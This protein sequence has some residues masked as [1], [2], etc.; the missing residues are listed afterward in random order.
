MSHNQPRKIRPGNLIVIYRNCINK[1]VW[2]YIDWTIPVIKS[3][4]LC[5]KTR[6]YGQCFLQ[7]HGKFGKYNSTRMHSIRMTMSAAV[8]RLH[9]R[10]STNGV[11]AKRG[12]LPREGSSVCQGGV[13]P[14]ECLT[15]VDVFPGGVCLGGCLPRS[16]LAYSA[17]W[18]E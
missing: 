15:Q 8:F 18:T 7:V 10:V 14:G 4:L 16:C 12:C 13:H 17:N 5:L 3:S 1:G 6:R 9:G 11:S 2:S